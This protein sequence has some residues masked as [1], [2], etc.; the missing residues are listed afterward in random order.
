[1]LRAST[2]PTECSRPQQALRHSCCQTQ[3]A[4]PS[5]L[6]P[7][8]QQGPDTGLG[9]AGSPPK[10]PVPLPPPMRKQVDQAPT[11]ARRPRRDPNPSVSDTRGPALASRRP[12]LQADVL[13]GGT[14][15]TTVPPTAAFRMYAGCWKGE[16]KWASRF[17]HS[18]I[19]SF[20]HPHTHPPS[21]LTRISRVPL[22][23]ALLVLVL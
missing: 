8:L 23:G 5:L 19:H 11:A 12:S 22:R 6:P 17:I 18:L 2:V 21:R 20:I 7:G 10:D 13:G 9:H 14:A 1:M 3:L 15:A 16:A 4:L